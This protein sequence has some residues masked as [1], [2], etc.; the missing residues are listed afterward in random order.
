VFGDDGHG[1]GQLDL[2]RAHAVLDARVYTRQLGAQPIDLSGI[3]VGGRARQRR[4][5]D[6]EEVAHRLRGE[7]G[8]SGSD[9]DAR[10]ASLRSLF[11]REQLQILA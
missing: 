1:A 3:G 9:A 10:E 6:D 5:A 4:F 8:E 2:G 7:K 11:R